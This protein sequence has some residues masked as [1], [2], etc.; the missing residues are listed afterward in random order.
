MNKNF[1]N[2]T[3]TWILCF[4]MLISS[5]PLEGI[6]F[7]ATTVSKVLYNTRHDGFNIESGYLEIHGTEL[8]NASILLRDTS[9]VLFEPENI[10]LQN[11]TI[12]LVDLTEA[13]TKKFK[14]EMLVS[15][16]TVNLN[17]ATF[18]TIGSGSSKNVNYG[19]NEDLTINGNNLEQIKPDAAGSGVE[20]RFGKV[21]TTEFFNPVPPSTSQITITDPVPPGGNGGFQDITFTRSTTS[22]A[23][24]VKVV[25]QYADVFRLVDNVGLNNP[26]MFPNIGAHGDVVYFTANNFNNTKNY[27]AYFLTD[28]TGGD[29]YKSTN[30]GE[31]VALS[32]DIDAEGNDKL[33]VKIPPRIKPPADPNFDIGTYYVVLVNESDGQVIAEQVVNKPGTLPAEP[34][35]Y[36]VIES[37][38]NP[39]ILAVNPTAGT[40]SG[41]PVTI[42]GSNILKVD[43]PT[44]IDND[45]I[46]SVATGSANTELQVTYNDGTYNGK[47]VHITRNIK[48]QIGKLVTFEAGD[49]SPGLVTQELLRMTTGVIP[50]AATDPV[51]DVQV[52]ITTTVQEVDDSNPATEEKTYVFRQTAIKENAYTFLPSTLTPVLTEVTPETMQMTGVGP[53][54][55]K[56]DTLMV[57]KGDDFLVD[58]IVEDDGTV[59]TRKPTVLIKK[60]ETR[61]SPNVYQIGFFPSDSV[62]SINGIIRTKVDEQLSTP[63]VFQKDGNT[64]EL[65]LTVLDDNNRVVDGTVGNDVGTKIVVRI[66]EEIPVT[67][68][69]IKQIQVINPKRGSAELGG[70]QFLID[71]LQFIISSD[72][73][74]IESVNPNIVTVAGGEK[75]KITGTNFQE[76]IKLYLDGEEITGFDK[77]KD[78]LGAKDII[79]FTAPPGREGTT[80]V[81]LIN[82][83]GGMDVRDFEYVIAFN[84]DPVITNFTPVRGT[85]TTLV[86]INGDNYLKPDTSVGDTLGVNGLRLI[87]TRVF[88]DGKDVNEYNKDAQGDIEFKAYTSPSSNYALLESASDQAIWSVFKDNTTLLKEGASPE[89]ALFNIS[90][91]GQ[92]NPLITNRDD[93]AY[94]ITY[95]LPNTRFLVTTPE[96]STPEL[97]TITQPSPGQTRIAFTIGG[98]SVAFVGTMDNKLIRKSQD[99]DGN[100]I[101]K[102]ADYAESIILTNGVNFFTLSEDFNGDVI[103]TNGSDVSYTLSVTG[104]NFF[105]EEENRPKVAVTVTNST[106]TIDGDAYTYLTPYVFDENA[107]GI[108]DNRIQGDHTKVINKN[109]I[110]FV[111]PSL[112]TGT[113][114]KDLEVINPDTRRAEKTGE[115][116]FYYIKQS[117]SHPVISEIKPNKGSIAGGYVIKITGSDFED[118]MKVYIDS[119]LVPE[120]DTYVAIDGTYVT[121]KV[122]ACIKDLQ[123]DFGIDSLSVPVVVLNEDGGS[124]YKE[125][126]FTYVVPV[127][128]PRIDQIILPDGSSNGGEIVEIIG[129]DFRYYEP[130]T[131]VGASGP[132]YNPGDKFDDLFKNNKWDDLLDPAVDPNAVRDVPFS[133]NPRFTVYKESEVLPTIFFGENEA[134]IVEYSKGYIKVIAPPH[135]AGSVPLYVVNNDQGVSNSVEYTY[136]AS[137]PTITQISPDKGNRTGQELKDI[138][139]ANFFR[140]ELKGYINNDADTIV[141]LPTVEANVRFG[142]IDNREIPNGQPNHGQINGGRADVALDG[143]L[144]ASYNGNTDTITLYVEENGKIYQRVFNN[145]DDSVV[146]IPMEMLMSGSEFYHPFGYT[147]ETPTVWKNKLYE[148]IRVS[149]EDRRLIVERGYAPKVEFISATRLTVVSPSYHTIDPVPLTVTNNDGG[150]ATATFTYTNPDSAPTILHINPYVKSADAS[151]FEVQA[152]IQGGVE[153]EVVGLDFRE[154][155]KA[156]IGSKPAEIVEETTRII[157]EVTY[158]VLI[159]KVPQGT[160]DDID[161]KYPVIVENAD[162]G[163]ANSTTISNLIGPNDGSNTLPFFFVY[164]KPLSG[165]VITEVDPAETSV[166]GGNQVVIKG[167]DFRAG[168]L[169]I[170]GTSGGVPVTG[171]II[172]EEGRILTI[173]T[174]TGMTIGDKTVQVINKDFGTGSKDNALK[175]VS[176]P[177]V[178]EEILSVDGDDSKNTVSVEGGEKVKIKGTGFLSGAKVYFGGTRTVHEEKPEGET[179][180]LFKDDTY[181][182]LKDAY[183]ATSVEVVD[184]NTMIVTTP[185]ITKEDTF[186]ITVINS[187]GG[188]S[189]DNADLQFSEPIPTTPQ[190][191]RVRVIDDRYIQ[192]YDYTS[193]GVEY[194]EVYYYLGTKTTSEIYRDDRQDMKYIGTTTLEPFKITRIPG[195]EDRRS[196][197]VLYFALK[198]VNKFGVSNWSN[199]AVL[200]YNQMKEIEELGPEDLDGDLGVPKGKEYIYDSDGETS[201]INL[202]EKSLGK[203]VTVDLRGVEEGNPETRII[204]VPREMVEK[205]QSLVYVNYLDSKLQFVPVGLNTPEFRELNFY[206]RAY[207]RIITSTAGNSYN[208]MLKLSMPRGKK[209]A[210]KIFTLDVEAVNNEESEVVNKF[211]APMD[212]QLVYND[213]YLSADQENSLQMY[214]FDKILN[215]WELMSATIDKENNLATVRTSKPGSYVVLYDR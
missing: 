78:P 186:N 6:S 182:E 22:G 5:V 16:E 118:D 62:G 126:G 147:D 156:F 10:T 214:R 100:A 110:S 140:S 178:E 206:D 42:Q 129:Y 112:K 24:Q 70:Y 51:K 101:V 60:D 18:P 205:S 125:N 74:S 144:R 149:V 180:G 159:L 15:G 105:A 2:K 8:E 148:Y 175:I 106:L 113:G 86:L 14:G 44:L 142:D 59:I 204:N 33:T 103:F 41:S 134:K 132:G 157:N 55:F 95:D 124:A 133:E 119:V 168:A 143:D 84:Q 209:T 29:D 39:L 48:I 54:E 109:Q 50:D 72:N 17:L 81:Q 23:T 179:V 128:N 69:G 127:S 7:A 57:I 136:T 183:E 158:D 184:E 104:N 19:N 130:Y 200:N 58:R 46:Q 9:N 181:I 173:T 3:L 192:L 211:S 52:E 187:D 75:V 191:L 93:E 213:T 145:Y 123:G 80:Q 99:D 34:D 45:T 28:L 40:D 1:F 189:E 185:E 114:Y 117:S 203:Q 36:T 64:V 137:A 195:F 212:L 77:T 11:A 21:Q 4:M 146:Y 151:Y 176:F 139:G 43:L 47:P 98:N 71:K 94:I 89:E 53:Y 197:E 190:N 32:L 161:Q 160:V 87:G 155:V 107:D 166:F 68:I 20:A 122:P 35:E 12:V 152:S 67:D 25:Y 169:V 27:N 49:Y 163:M 188:I 177:T 165:P 170:I 102:A 202:S 92:G 38:Y 31:F 26:E 141:T 13:E 199:F 131:D 73:P 96:I 63:V 193:E 198:A 82:P 150:K 164:R 108:N 215:K 88:L 76:G 116:G 174:P 138:Y 30:R 162:A 85:A 56:H 90:N 208:S 37:S 111:V 153:I 83:S 121:V 135:D 61:V 207:G 79:E 194:Y 171:G 115:E 210:T 201:V 66:P 91:D 120:D 167:S 172:T 196:N 97:V 154:G 65:D